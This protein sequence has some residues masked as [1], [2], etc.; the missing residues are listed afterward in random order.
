VGRGSVPRGWGGWGGDGRGIKR[1]P[2]GSTKRESLNNG[3]S[4]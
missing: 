4:T 3:R 1:F 2:E